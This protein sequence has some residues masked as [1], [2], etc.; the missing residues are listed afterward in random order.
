METS[1]WLLNRLRELNVHV[2]EDS[3]PK[4]HGVWVPLIYAWPAP[5]FPVYQLSLN[6]DAGLE[7]HWELGQHLQALREEGVLIVGSG[8]ITHNLRALDRHAGEDEILPW[9]STFIE[10]VEYAI[11]NNDRAALTNPWKFSYGKE[12]HPT[13][14]HYVP[15]LFAMG[16]AD[17]EQV[18]LMHRASVYGTLSLNA[19]GAGV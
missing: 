13:V 1:A 2:Q 17:G 4:D 12:C 16:A 10:E 9:A 14:E 15:L 5:D 8:G 11:F 19:Y 3:W 18:K 6:Q 7:S